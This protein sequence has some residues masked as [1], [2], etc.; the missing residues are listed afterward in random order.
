M[1]SGQLKLNGGA[2]DLET[3]WTPITTQAHAEAEAWIRTTLRAFG[4]QALAAWP[5]F[6]HYHR[7]LALFWCGVYGA[8]ILT[9]DQKALLRLMDCREEIKALDSIGDDPDSETDDAVLGGRMERDDDLF[10]VPSVNA[11]GS[12][13]GDVFNVP[14]WPYVRDVR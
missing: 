9:E 5:M 12:L 10:A 14:T 7:R 1:L 13:P 2:D 6:E 8:A 3:F 11:G 4:S